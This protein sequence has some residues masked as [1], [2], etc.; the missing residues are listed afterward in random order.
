M[1][2]VKITVDGIVQGVGFRYFALRIA[3]K[4]GITGWVRNRLRG[5]VEIYAEG[6]ESSLEPFIAEI[7][8]GPRFGRVDALS[9][10]WRQYTGK[11]LEFNIK[12]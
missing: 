11:F 10:E 12:H 9:K 4:Y 6:S 2:A 3:E 7:K 1:K 8:M 5:D